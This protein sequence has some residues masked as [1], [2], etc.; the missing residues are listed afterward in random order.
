MA[1]LSARAEALERLAYEQGEEELGLGGNPWD[2]GKIVKMIQKSNNLSKEILT[3][4]RKQK[5]K[6]KKG[7]GKGKKGK[8]LEDAMEEVSIGAEEGG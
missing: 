3:Y 6:G 4:V 2:D 5:G 7:K 8:K 1:A